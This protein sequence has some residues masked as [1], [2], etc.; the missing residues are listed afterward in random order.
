[1]LYNLYKPKSLLVILLIKLL[2]IGHIFM[3]VFISTNAFADLIGDNLWWFTDAKFSADG[4][5]D[6][7]NQAYSIIYFTAVYIVYLFILILTL[8]AHDLDSVAIWI[9]QYVKRQ[10]CSFNNLLS[11][12]ALNL[13]SFLVALRNP[14]QLK[15]SNFALRQAQV[16]SSYLPFV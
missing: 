11:Q 7:I 4:Y 9:V 3:A 15:I 13:E 12:I 5:S 2:I 8:T 14:V 16:A 6:L 10:V 1:M